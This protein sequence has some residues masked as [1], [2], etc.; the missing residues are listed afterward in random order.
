MIAC[1][2]LL[3]YF[4]IS[5]L[6][7]KRRLEAEIMVLRHQLNVLRRAAPSRLRFT[8]TDRLIFVWIYRL[9]P[10]LIDAVAI[11]KPATVVPTVYS[12]GCPYRLCHPHV[13]VME[14]A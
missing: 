9:F 14:A 5:V 8:F 3:A 4:L 6:K 1:L 11:V 12:T 7:S 2:R 10:S 13:V